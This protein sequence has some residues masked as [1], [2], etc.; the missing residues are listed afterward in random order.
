M[1]T[2]HIRQADGTTQTLDSVADLTQQWS[3]KEATI[4]IDLEQPSE[5]EVRT[6][7][8]VVDLDDEA[9]EDCLHG[10]QRPRIDE[11]NGYVFIVLYGLLG[12]KK[13]SDLRPRKLAVFCGNQFLITVHR[14]PLQMVEHLRARC[15]QHP[16]QL[17]QSGV[18]HLL[19]Y[20]MDGMADNYLRVA[21]KYEARL[22]G[23][24]DRSQEPAPDD[25]LLADAAQLRRDLLELRRVAAAQMELIEPVSEGEFDY[26]SEALGRRFAHVRDHLLKV[27]EHVDSLR[28]LMNG[29]RD[30]YHAA[31]ANRTNAIMRTVTILASVLLPLSFIAGIYGM[32][33]PLWPKPDHPA[34]FWGVM[35][36][37]GVIAGGLLWCFRR[38]KWL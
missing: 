36:V 31:L 28:E 8:A 23:L 19:Y 27:I 24:E 13:E 1:F 7:D 9:W 16:A 32:N 18:D 33:L 12:S 22:E 30:N 5:D 17:L 6:V 38:K 29:I 37:M 15:R 11:Y 14:E 26:I 3:D 34:T 4:W 25:S 2:A 20:I 21:E 35:C 10:E